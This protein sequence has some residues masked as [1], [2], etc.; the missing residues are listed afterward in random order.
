[1]SNNDISKELDRYK[2]ESK[3]GWRSLHQ[4]I[5]YLQFPADWKVKIIPPFGGATARFL[6]RTDKMQEGKVISVYLDHFARLGCEDYPYW[7]CYPN[8]STDDISRFRMEDT[9]GLL[10]ELAG[11]VKRLEK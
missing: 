9:E 2:V 7:E 10:A 3:E 6:I 11:T 5:P 1:M 8:A 4:G